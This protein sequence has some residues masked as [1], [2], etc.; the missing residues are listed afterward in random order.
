MDKYYL[1]KEDQAI[2]QLDFTNNLHKKRLLSIAAL[3]VNSEIKE[4]FKDG[5]NA[6]T[7]G[8]SCP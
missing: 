8:I 7:K 4:F 6:F 1:T 5:V 2:V 3:D